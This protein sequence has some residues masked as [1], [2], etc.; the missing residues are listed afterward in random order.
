MK[1]TI[2][3]ENNS[4]IDNYLLAEPAF[5]AL[6]ECKN[7]KILFDLGYSDVFIKNA[8]SMNINLN[9]ITD[10]VISHGHNDHTG[11]FLY[12][13]PKNNNINIIA[14]PNIFDKKTDEIGNNY[15]CPLTLKQLKQH[16]NLNLT[17]KPLY[18]TKNLLFLGKIENNYSDDIDDSALVYIM[19]DKLFIITGCSHSGIINIVNYAKKVT[20]INKIYGILGGFH[21]IDKSDEDI[22]NVSKFLKNENIELLAPCHCCDLRSKILLSEL[23]IIKE[24]CVGDIFELD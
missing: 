6:I 4:R 18:L 8:K 13:K 22:K 16:Y 7:K 5:S 21:L 11:G 9:D 23:N 24:V 2:L 12:Y 15:G 10:I 14:H 19:N 20:K 17:G 1:I 3:N